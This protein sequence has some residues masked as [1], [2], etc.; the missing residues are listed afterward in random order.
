MFVQPFLPV[1]G[2]FGALQGVRPVYRN[3]RPRAV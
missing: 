2:Q 3:L 1:A